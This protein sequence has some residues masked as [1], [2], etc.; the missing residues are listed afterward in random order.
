MT[1]FLV[2]LGVS[3]P[4]LT[5]PLFLP[6]VKHKAPETEQILLMAFWAIGLGLFVSY[7]SAW[8]LDF[9][10]PTTL[11]Q[12]GTRLPPIDRY[13]L[14]GSWCLYSP[15]S[16]SPAKLALGR[17]IHFD[18]QLWHSSSKLVVGGLD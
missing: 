12:P 5:H 13:L 3:L 16:L 1:A 11:Y 18:L 9:F 4:V 10:H 2:R 8:Y 15:H 14:S 17:I 6:T 7:S